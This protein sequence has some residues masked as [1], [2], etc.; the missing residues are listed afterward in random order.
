LLKSA[1]YI[2][3]PAR[4]DEIFDHISLEIFMIAKF[5]VKI[6]CHLTQVEICILN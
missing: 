1:L 3:K 5:N 4:A 2:V 6:P